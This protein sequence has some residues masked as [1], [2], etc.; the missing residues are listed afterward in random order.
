MRLYDIRTGHD[1]FKYIMN[2]MGLSPS[3]SCDCG[4]A[5]QTA[6]HMAS[7]CPL[8]RCNGDL[9]VPPDTQPAAR[10]AV[11]RRE[12]SRIKRKK[13]LKTVPTFPDDVT[14]PHA[15]VPAAFNYPVLWVI[16]KGQG[17]NSNHNHNPKHIYNH[18][19]NIIMT[20]TLCLPAVTISPQPQP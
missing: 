2:Q 17:V 1:R 14:G 20:L 6:H 18:N 12:E 3:A 5:N 4:A 11:G 7:K 10:P 16:V 9:V 8:H 15:R 19:P 13:M